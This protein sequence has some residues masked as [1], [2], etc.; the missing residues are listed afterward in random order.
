METKFRSDIATT[1][2]FCQLAMPQHDPA[3]DEIEK[4]FCTEFDYRGEGN[5]L[6]LIRD[7]IMPQW[8]SQ[9]EIPKP[10]LE[11]CSKHILV[12]DYLEVKIDYI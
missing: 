7:A 10:Y 11:Y 4:Q 1:K 9:V 2:A 3:F 5:N 6:K 12:M 8:G